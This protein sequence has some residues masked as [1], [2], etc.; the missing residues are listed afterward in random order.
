M[1][2]TKQSSTMTWTGDARGKEEAADVPLMEELGETIVGLKGR[3]SDNAGLAG[4]GTY[5][6]SISSVSL[7]ACALPHCTAACEDRRV[8][9][10]RHTRDRQKPTP[11]ERCVCDGWRETE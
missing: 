8:C 9:E 7:A 2:R 1:Y 5:F 11:S 3:G 6:E 10:K 4:E